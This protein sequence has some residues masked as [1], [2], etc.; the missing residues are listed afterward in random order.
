MKNK[1]G[2]VMIVEV[3]STKNLKGVVAQ[4]DLESRTNE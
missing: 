3:L 4:S 1:K 2:H